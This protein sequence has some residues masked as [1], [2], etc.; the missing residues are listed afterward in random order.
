LCDTGVTRIEE[1]LTT[2]AKIL[3]LF[4]ELRR[5]H[6]FKVGGAYAVGAWVFV[7]LTAIVAPELHAPEGTVLFVIV[8]AVIGLPLAI[9][10]SWVYELTPQGFRQTRELLTNGPAV[11][12]SAADA[13]S[14]AAL[15]AVAVL[16]F[17]K[18]TPTAPY[19]YLADALPIEL[20]SL[21]SRI[22]ELRVVSRKSSVAH[23]GAGSDLQTIARDLRVQYVISGSVAEIGDR[24]QIHVQ[25]DDAVDDT[26]L[27]SE[28]YDVA[29]ADVERLER[30]ISEKV[31]ATFG[32]ERL[33]VEIRRANEGAAADSSAWQLVQKA[34][35]YLLDYTPTSIAAAIPLLRRAVELDPQYAVGYATLGLV[36]AE[37]TLNALS[38]DVAADRRFALE[39]IARAERLA[40][41]DAVVLRAAGC[42][43]AY[44]GN[45]RYSIEL[46]RRAVKLAPYELGAWGYLGWPLVSTGKAADLAEVHE[47]VERLL[48]TS[49]QH[50]GRVYWL[51]HRSVA[52]ACADDCERSLAESEEYTSEQPQFSLGSM[53]HA[54]V[55][56]RLGRHDDARAAVERSMQHN[57]LMTPLYYAELMTVLTD[58]PAVVDKRTS[59]L[60]SAGIIKA[61]PPIRPSA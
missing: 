53:H 18:L 33:R 29:A 55:L 36:T 38:A 41:R 26:L 58:Q 60:T 16:P 48:A 19:A 23:S 20:Q 49:P 43:H 17:G 7:Q 32:G 13:H 45:Y 30:E 44:T 25:L 56:G 22:P 3:W 37:R 1:A 4:Q 8:L 46:L 39:V 34:R 21:L 11:V 2:R 54:N 5:R 61:V 27:W 40:P 9:A 14:Q 12:A 31:V 24:L 50:P 57:P 6:V 42:V 15:A 47:I 35:A 59:G 51:F 10:L 52:Y 28:R